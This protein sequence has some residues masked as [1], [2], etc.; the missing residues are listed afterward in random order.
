MTFQCSKSCGSG[1]RQRAVVC[2]NE[3]GEESQ[4]YCDYLTKPNETLECNTHSC[5]V[6]NYGAW[7]KCDGTCQKHRLVTCVNA[8]SVVINETQCD[9]LIK[10]PETERCLQ[11]ECF[12]FK[13]TNDDKRYKWKIGK[14]SQVGVNR[15]FLCSVFL[16]IFQFLSVR[17]LAVKV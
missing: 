12:V 9:I 16:A 15:L 8:R 2:R 6:W 5:P 1:V 11:N 17:N 4:Y 10:P 14:W 7:T 3:L 13:K